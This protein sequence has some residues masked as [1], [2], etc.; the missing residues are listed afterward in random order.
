MTE[1]LKDPR[2]RWLEYDALD[3]PGDS[4]ALTFDE[5]LWLQGRL[6][7]RWGFDEKDPARPPTFEEKTGWPAAHG[8]HVRR[9]IAKFGHLRSGLRAKET[10][11]QTFRDI[12]DKLKH[13]SPQDDAETQE[14]ESDL[15]A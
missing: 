9:L 3:R 1:A 5:A 7:E 8:E 14:Q 15:A 4:S 6:I 13:W 12:I 11:E 10:R 2:R